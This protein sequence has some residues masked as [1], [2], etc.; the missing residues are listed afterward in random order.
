MSPTSS[1]LRRSVASS[2]AV[3]VLNDVARLPSSSSPVTGTRSTYRPSAIRRLA[4][5]R[6]AIGRDKR[7]IG[8]DKRAEKARLTTRATAMA[9][10]AAIIRAV[11]TASL[12]A[13][14]TRLLIMS[15]IPYIE[16][17]IA[18]SNACARRHGH[19]PS[20]GITPCGGSPAAGGEE[21]EV[22]SL[23]IPV[24]L[25]PAMRIGSVMLLRFVHRRTLAIA[26]V[27]L[28]PCLPNLRNY[29]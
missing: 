10:N 21:Q 25:E 19:P 2:D 24:P 20:V 14:R 23:L 3:I 4:A 13:A 1:I 29:V 27:L 11:W 28:C 9:T 12:N 7:A 15:P 16:G 5:A 6:R 17:P 8:R 18:A 26:S 22:R